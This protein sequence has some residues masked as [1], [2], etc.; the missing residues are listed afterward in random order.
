MRMPQR[1]KRSQPMA[2]EARTP[3]CGT[4]ETNTKP[5]KGGT[6]KDHPLVT[7]QATRCSVRLL[8]R[9]ALT[10]LTLYQIATYLYR[11]GVTALSRTKVRSPEAG[12]RPK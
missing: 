5:C 12:T 10:S 3:P 1:G 2:S 9:T 8:H 7:F 6:E 11:F 4:H